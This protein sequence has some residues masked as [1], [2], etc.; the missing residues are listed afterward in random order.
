[1]AWK[2][3]LRSLRL[4]GQEALEAAREK[5]RPAQPDSK[6][7]VTPSPAGSG[8]A[9][10]PAPDESVAPPL[11]N[12]MAGRNP[13]GDTGKLVA[14]EF[15]QRRYRAFGDVVAS[16]VLA[17]AMQPGGLQRLLT[18]LGLKPWSNESLDHEQV[19]Q[20]LRE[21][22]PDEF[23]RRMGIR[24]PGNGEAVPAASPKTPPAV[25]PAGGAS[26]SGAATTSSKPGP[27]S[28]SRAVPGGRIVPSP[29]S[30]TSRV[31]VEGAALQPVRISAEAQ[32][33]SALGK[34]RL[35][36]AATG[37]GFASPSETTPQQT[38][39]DVG[40][41][42]APEITPAHSAESEASSPGASEAAVAEPGV[43][44]TPFSALWHPKASPGDEDTQEIKPRT[45]VTPMPMPLPLPSRETTP[46]ELLRKALDEQT[47]ALLQPRKKEAEKE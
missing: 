17:H 15:V 45:H 22:G 33:R 16:S 40:F 9:S 1:M 10:A 2:D 24:R 8:A 13:G 27:V 18:R 35:G 23:C 6:D 41:V 12:P 29:E 26:S 34:S 36:E 19:V 43:P 44:A 3:L 4:T 20:F 21:K 31:R 14:I 7:I 25:A 30:M 11:R 5:L 37:A 46:D 39:S 47:S 38:E 28:S 32:R 42:E